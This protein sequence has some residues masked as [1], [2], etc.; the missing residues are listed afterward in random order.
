MANLRLPFESLWLRCSESGLF[1]TLWVPGGM[2]DPG[3]GRY[4]SFRSLELPATHLFSL[5][6]KGTSITL[7]PRGSLNALVKRWK[8]KL[9]LA[10][11]PVGPRQA[12]ILRPS[13]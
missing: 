10:E 11:I 13:K 5:H 4:Q 7:G 1:L 9:K 3:L 12:A 8:C 6:P 2:L